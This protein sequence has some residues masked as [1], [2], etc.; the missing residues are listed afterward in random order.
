[1]GKAQQIKDTGDLDMG[2]LNTIPMRPPEQVMRLARMGSFHQSRLSFMRVLLRRMAAENWQITQTDW[3]VDGAGVGHAVY[4][5]KTPLRVYSLVVFAHDLPD[6]LRSDR[7]IAEAWDVTFTLFDGVPTDADITR[8]SQN[9]PYQEVGRV[10]PREIVLSRANRSLRAWDYALEK[11]AKGEQPDADKILQVGYFMRTTAVYGSGKFGAADRR[12]LLDRPELHAPFQAEMLAVYLIRC[13][14]MDL[15]DFRAKAMGGA[16]ATRLAPALRRQCGIGNSTG[17]GMAPFLVHHPALIHCWVAAKEAALARVRGVKT[18][19][20]SERD[21]MR[22]ALCVAQDSA[23]AW[24]SEHPIAKPKIAELRGDLARAVAAF[25]TELPADYPWDWLYKWGEANLS[26]EGSEQIASVLLEPY[27]DLVDGLVECLSIDET[28][29]YR[30]NGAMGADELR[31]AIE[32]IYPWALALDFTEPANIAR[33]WYVS[34][35]KLEP[36]L[37]ERF[38]ENGADLEQPLAIGRDIAGLY[39]ATGAGGSVADILLAAPEFRHTARRVQIAMRFPY[40]E[41]RDNLVDEGMMPIDLLRFK[42]SF[43][44]ATHFDPRSDRWLRISM[45]AGAPFPD[46]LRVDDCWVRPFGGA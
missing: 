41:I 25:D 37:G 39:Q 6:D 1:M 30:I 35:A 14:V 23:Q 15:L 22:V 26:L 9:V 45:F 20:A 16:A 34:E 40:S 27:G 28:L 12:D 29:Y 33:F 7:V 8:L 46:E 19:A 44:G 2:D 5:A 13:F 11:L 18:P 43:F 42:L 24:Q 31:S 21:A 10:S 4:Q 38:E 32:R 17:L 3:Q 36:R